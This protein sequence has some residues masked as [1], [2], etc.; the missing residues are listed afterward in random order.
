MQRGVVRLAGKP[1]VQGTI[2]RMA[3]Q[4]IA[5]LLERAAIEAPACKCRV[6]DGLRAGGGRRA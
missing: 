3:Q 2:D 5:G 6:A 1:C 4:Q